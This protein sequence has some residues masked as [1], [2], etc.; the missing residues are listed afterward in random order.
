MTDLLSKV[1]DIAKRIRSIV[2]VMGL[3]KLFGKKN[4]VDLTPYLRRID[5]LE[6]LLINANNLSNA[7]KAEIAGQVKRIETLIND[8][9]KREDELN[10]LR[11]ESMKPIKERKERIASVNS[12]KL[13]VKRTNNLALVGPSG[14]GKSTFLWLLGKGEEPKRSLDH[15]TKE[16][17]YNHGFID[18]IGIDWELQS[19]LKLIVLFLY[20]G[21]PSE[22]IC[23][24]GS[25]VQLVI[26]ALSTLGLPTPLI[27]D[28]QSQSFWKHL[29]RKKI[30]LETDKNGVRRVRPLED[31]DFIYS[32]DTYNMMSELG[33]GKGITH[34]DNI[35]ELIKQRQQNGLDSFTPIFQTLGSTFTVPEGE[36]KPAIE[37]LFRFIWLFE[38]VYKKDKFRFMKHCQLEDFANTPTP[39]L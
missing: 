10:R 1:E 16:L 24:S 2:E 3:K 35:E 30:H 23:F 4:K 22:M 7:Q 21:F 28:I 27:V 25:R 36:T 38:N 31:L 37:Y 5:E 9:K 20:E 14:I 12:L 26:T 15:G 33:V 29:E 32:F 39:K 17:N 6:K 13:E 19:L 8:F 11:N 18:T 34:Q